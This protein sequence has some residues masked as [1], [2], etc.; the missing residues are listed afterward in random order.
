MVLLWVLIL[1][2]TSCS[3]KESEISK[4]LKAAFPDD[5]VSVEKSDSTFDRSLNDTCVVS[6]ETHFDDIFIKCDCSDEDC[7]EKAKK[8]VTIYVQDLEYINWEKRH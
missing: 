1:I 6:V 2:N 5:I 8:A 3:D 4:D 7:I